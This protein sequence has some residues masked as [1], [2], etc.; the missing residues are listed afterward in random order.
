[1][2]YQSVD[3]LQQALVEKVFHY[4]EDRKKAA[5]RAPGMLAGIVTCY[6]L[7]GLGF[8]DGAAI[9][10]GLPEYKNP[11]VTH[12]VEWLKES[13]NFRRIF[14]NPPCGIDHER[15]ASIKHWLCRCAAAHS[16]RASEVP[17]I[18]PVATNT[19]HWKKHVFGCAAAACSLY[20]TRLSLLIEGRD[21]GKGAPMPCAMVYWGE[22]HGQFFDVFIQHVAVVDL[23][24]L[25]RKH[26]G[27]N[28]RQPGP[29]PPAEI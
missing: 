5:G 4:A 6:A 19:G 24:P 29:I 13:W 26:T 16:R 12:N 17:E 9:E 23:R 18:A 22:N 25:F 2:S 28:V 10:R 15:G 8:R 3:A 7:K 14:A 11:G 27:N 1:M 20:D 21:E